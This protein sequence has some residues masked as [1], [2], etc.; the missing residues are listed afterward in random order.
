MENQQNQN[1]TQTCSKC[2]ET[3][4]LDKYSNPTKE[5]RCRAC[6]KSAKNST[7]KKDPVLDIEPTNLDCET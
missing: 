6:V 5:K 4:T 7:N 2:K 1:L 3:L